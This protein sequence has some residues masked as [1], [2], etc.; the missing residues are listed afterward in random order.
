MT[1]HNFNRIDDV[2]DVSSSAD[3]TATTATGHQPEAPVQV[4][5]PQSSI[6]LKAPGGS[7]Y[8]DLK[9]E[10]VAHFLGG[11]MSVKGGHLSFGLGGLSFGGV[12]E[13]ESLTVKG[14]LVVQKGAHI[15]A[16]VTCDRLINLGTI[17][18]DSEVIVHG[19]LVGW[20]GS[21]RAKNGIYARAMQLT[22]NCKL[23]GEIKDL[24]T[25][26]SVQQEGASS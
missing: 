17:D 18:S 7:L 24:D 6:A 20:E 4:A 23:L 15:T 8:V 12:L 16:S 9:A 22:Q 10:G 5:A 19:L 13:A 26:S 25:I 21:I 3:M 14:T 2:S 1:L 11:G